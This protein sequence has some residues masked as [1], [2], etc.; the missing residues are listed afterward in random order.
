MPP[1]ACTE[2]PPSCEAISAGAADD[3]PFTADNLAGFKFGNVRT[4]FHDLSDK[5]VAHYHGHGN[6]LLRPPIP[7]ENAHIGSADSGAVD[8]HENIVDAGFRYRHHLQQKSGLRVSFDERFHS[9][10]FSPLFPTSEIL[11][12]S[13]DVS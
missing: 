3:V 6:R 4:H 8:P 13:F 10:F 9:S 2:V 7:V 1:G 12:F 5:F 11:L